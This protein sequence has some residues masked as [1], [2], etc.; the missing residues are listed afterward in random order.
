MGNKSKSP[1]VVY[2]TIDDA[3]SPPG[4]EFLVNSAK[5]KHHFNGCIA[6]AADSRDFRVLDSGS[7]MSYGGDSYDIDGMRDDIVRMMKRSGAD[8]LMVWLEAVM[9]GFDKESSGDNQA[10]FQAIRTLENSDF[11]P[12]PL[13]KQRMHM[14]SIQSRTSD[15]AFFA[16]PS[17]NPYSVREVEPGQMLFGRWS[18]MVIEACVDWN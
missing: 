2:Q 14:Y 13:S 12:K 15:R 10:V 5:D 6:I 3:Q 8:Y 4:L 1:S 7:F 9:Y 18:G 17:D 11:G 16:I